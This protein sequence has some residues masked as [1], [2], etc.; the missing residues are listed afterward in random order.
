ME[1]DYA[2]IIYLDNSKEFDGLSQII[3]KRKFK[4]LTFSRLTVKM[5][6]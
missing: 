6:C 3:Y 5:A 2:N 1:G 4:S